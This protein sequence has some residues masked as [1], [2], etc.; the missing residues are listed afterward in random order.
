M[1]QYLETG[2]K[3]SLVVLA[4]NRPDYLKQ[5]LDSLLDVDGV[6]K[7]DIIV[8][9]DGNDAS[10][11]Q[12]VQDYGL[13]IVHNNMK[14]NL[15]GRDGAAKIATH[16]KFAISNGFAFNPRSPAII[17]IEDDFLFSPD[18]LQYFESN[19]PV[20]DE[21]PTTFIMSAWNDN[22]LAVH[23]SDKQKIHRTNYCPGLGWL[24]PRKLWEQ[25]LEKKWP[26]T[27]WDHWM[28]DPKQHKGRDC[29]HPEVPRDYHIGVKGTFMDDFHHNTY[30]KD[31]G[32]NRDVGF[33]WSGN[34]W[35]N[36]VHAKYDEDIVAKI[37]GGQ[38]LVSLAQLESE[39]DQVFVIYINVKI[40]L[41]SQPFK[42]I[43]QYF[44]IWHE[45]E[46][47]NYDGLHQFGWKNGNYIIIVNEAEAGT[48][49]KNL[50]T[51]GKVWRPEE[52]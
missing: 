14:G 24:M 44:S 52:F 37:K 35:Q 8:V 27:H 43:G 38:E 3:F 49:F 21:D 47:G 23:V 13:N 34:E 40:G 30:F 10:V 20:L 15:R 11:I 5:T 32:Y 9:Q 1:K 36:A 29:L 41:P 16:Y 12:V 42:K 22:G 45:I 4:C 2:E 25:E 33:Q 48:T 50:K 19:S 46:R 51:G 31:I 39:R 17:I 7:E 6:R 28:R 18:F 26:K